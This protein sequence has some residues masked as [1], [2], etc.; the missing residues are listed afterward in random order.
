[1]EDGYEALLAVNWHCSLKG[2]MR[3]INQRLLHAYVLAE[4]GQWE[5][6]VE[7]LKIKVLKDRRDERIWLRIVIVLPIVLTALFIFVRHTGDGLFGLLALFGGLLWFLTV[8]SGVLE[9][10]TNLWRKWV[11]MFK[12]FEKLFDFLHNPDYGGFSWVYHPDGIGTQNHKGTYEFLCER[13][14][15]ELRR[16]ALTVVS[17]EKYDD[18]DCSYQ[19]TIEQDKLREMHRVAKDLGLANPK[20]E[21]YFPKETSKKVAK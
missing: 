9:R 1:M 14:D 17:L 5:V 11:R 19:H 20:I 6:S 21:T 10:D 7:E 18:L 13:V 16:Q 3:K 2:Q 4:K 12:E 8:L 15:K